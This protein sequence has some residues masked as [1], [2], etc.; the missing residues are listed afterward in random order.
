MPWQRLRW[1][2]TTQYSQTDGSANLCRCNSTARHHAP[3]VLRPRCHTLPL[4]VALRLG[5]E[6]RRGPSADAARRGAHGGILM[7]GDFLGVGSV[8]AMLG[9]SLV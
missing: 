7:R 6:A 4:L 1:G 5:V 9:G 3:V 8:A 2:R